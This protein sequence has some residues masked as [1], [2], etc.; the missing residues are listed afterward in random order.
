MST[1][2]YGGFI[3]TFEPGRS[4]TID[5][6]LRHRSKEVTTTIS[7]K[8]W[9]LQQRELVALSLFDH[10]PGIDGLA[11]MERAGGNAVTAAWRMRIHSPVMFEKPVKFS[12]LPRRLRSLG[13]RSSGIVLKR[14]TKVQWTELLDCIATLRP[15]QSSAISQLVRARS[16]DHRLFPS[17]QREVR[18]LEERDA[19]GVAV[20]IAGLDRPRLLKSLDVETVPNATTVLDLLELE[21]MH[22]QDAIRQD[23]KAFGALLQPGMRHARLADGRGTELRV[24]VYDKKALETVL[25]IDLLI[26]Q[27]LFDSFILIQ[28]KMMKRAKATDNSWSYTVD[29]QTQKQLAA[30]RAAATSLKKNTSDRE[31]IT[32]WRLSDEP[33]YWKFCEPTRIKDSAGAL[34]H[35]LTLSR[36]HFERFLS[37]PDSKGT[38]GSRKIGYANCHRYLTNSQLTDLASNG[39]IGGGPSCSSLIRRILTA[40]QTGGRRAMLV[41][42]QSRDSIGARERGWKTQ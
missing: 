20:D 6:V 26:Y 24:H 32:D 12:E 37:L 17:S 4:E 40:N 5:F 38:S 21:P 34:T 18:L 31:T 16:V 28:Y 13:L 14:L 7:A 22:E 29:R 1:S 11:L 10:H 3:L 36:P 41:A 25:G 9:T 42:I 19:I 35:G 8:D 27:Q 2:R 33:F 23:Q 15:E 30:M 39:W